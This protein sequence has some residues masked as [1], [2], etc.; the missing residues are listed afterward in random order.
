MKT[1]LSLAMLSVTSL[2]SGTSDAQVAQL[3]PAKPRFSITIKTTPSKVKAGADVV[4]EAEMKNVSAEDIFD[5]FAEGCY[6]QGTTSFRWEIRDSDGKQVP[7]T[8][9]GIKANHL[10][11][12][13]GSVGPYVPVCVNVISYPLGPGKTVMQKL[14]LSKEYDLSKPGKYSIQALRGDT[15]TTDVKS[16]TITLTVTP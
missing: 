1:L 16:N 7:M 2:V 4:V 10:E 5:S 8:E 13:P 9:Y 6:G 14:A 12:P 3:A 11:P 15:T